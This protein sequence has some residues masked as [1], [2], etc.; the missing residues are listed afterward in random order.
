M[1]DKY[2]E[3]AIEIMC[4]HGPSDEYRCSPDDLTIRDKRTARRIAAALREQ[5]QPTSSPDARDVEVAKKIVDCYIDGN[6]YGEVVDGLVS[7][8]AHALSAARREGSLPACYKCGQT[9]EEERRGVSCEAC[10]QRMGVAVLG[11]LEENR[12]GI[13]EAIRADERAKVMRE[14]WT[15]TVDSQAAEA[16][17]GNP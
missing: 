4:T 17:K 3:M 9:V 15:T 12:K 14:L 13:E 7:D 6:L 8:F 5:D 11:K 16:A 1:S 10:A 2:D